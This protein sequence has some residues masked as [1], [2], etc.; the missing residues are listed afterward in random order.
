MVVASVSLNL[1]LYLYLGSTGCTGVP[2]VLPK[3]ISRSVYDTHSAETVS[4]VPVDAT[5]I[6]TQPSISQ[7]CVQPALHE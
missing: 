2:R 6:D 1:Y 3:A 7:S 5:L 4:L